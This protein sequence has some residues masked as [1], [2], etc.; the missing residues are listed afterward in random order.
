MLL[1]F[2]AMLAAAALGFALR[3]QS[4]PRKTLSQSV[5][6]AIL[7]LM[8]MIGIEIGASPQVVALFGSIIGSAVALTIA[9]LLG[10][11]AAAAAL[12]RWILHLRAEPV[13][14]TPKKQSN[15]FSL[16][17][18]AAFALGVAIGLSFEVPFAVSTYATVALYLLMALVGFSIG[19]DVAVLAA[20]KSQ[21]WRA[22]LLPAAT[23]IGTLGGVWLLSPL[24]A[25]PTTD[26]LAVGSGFGYYSLSSVLLGELRGPALGAIALLANVLRELITVVAAP[27]IVRR[28]S[29][30]ALIASG[31]ATTIDITLP[32]ITRHIGP[33][34]LPIAVFHGVVV[35]LSVPLL[36]T[37]FASI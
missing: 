2:A 16:W 34:A 24:L 36:V 19:S 17:L 23:I 12:N 14:Q 22:A 33:K 1:I 30:A 3:N 27:W 8:A 35:D 9:A 11:W 13:A 37:F 7:L 26:Q 5:S 29:P 18:L 6:T 15:A 10:T 25:L 21:S 28:I 4:I 20:L 32:V 31:G